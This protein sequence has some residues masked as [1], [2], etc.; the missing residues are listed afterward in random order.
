M[1]HS[2]C[3]CCRAR[4]MVPKGFDMVRSD[5]QNRMDR[6]RYGSGE[7]VEIESCGSARLECAP[8]CAPKVHGEVRA[9]GYHWQATGMTLAFMHEKTRIP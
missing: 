1:R 4:F 5:R 8:K 3:E 2:G 7:R 9:A 6:I